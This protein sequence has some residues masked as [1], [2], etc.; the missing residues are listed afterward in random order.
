[1]YLHLSFF[2]RFIWNINSECENTTFNIKNGDKIES[3]EGVGTLNET[4]IEPSKG[5]GVRNIEISCQNDD[6]S[7][8]L[9]EYEFELLYGA[10]YQ[11]VYIEHP[12]T[13][14]MVGAIYSSVH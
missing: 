14:D 8:I 6:S 10:N 2:Q 3:I 4:A 7:T 12:E 13:D 11:F 1:M 5:V 9:E